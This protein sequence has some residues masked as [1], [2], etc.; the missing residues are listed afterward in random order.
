MVYNDI[1]LYLGCQTVTFF[2]GG[3]R[4]SIDTRKPLEFSFYD[5]QT[6]SQLRQET[7]NVE[8]Q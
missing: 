4:E 8:S 6:E 2:A 5:G 1:S 7:L 3:A